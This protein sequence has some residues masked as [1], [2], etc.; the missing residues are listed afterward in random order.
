LAAAVYRFAPEWR[1]SS[2]LPKVPIKSLAEFAGLNRDTLYEVVRTRRASVLVRIR[3]TWAIKNIDAGRV[4]FC[5]DRRTQAL[6]WE[7]CTG[8]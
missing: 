8:P 7:V 6:T 5:R 1:E 2:G 3:L 4:R